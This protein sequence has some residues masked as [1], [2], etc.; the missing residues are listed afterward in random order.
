MKTMKRFGAIALVLALIVTLF[1]ACGKP[2]VKEQLVGSWRDSAGIIGFD[3]NEDGTGS[4]VALDFTLPILNISLKGNYDMNYTV[5]TDDNDVTT[6]H[7]SF[8]YAVPISLDFTI[9]VDGDILKLAHESGLN[10]TMTR[11]VEADTDAAG[12]PV[13]E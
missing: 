10:Y 7:I 12:E 9:T 8:D 4:I 13:S 2:S 11:V 3:F 1:A 6:L 5:A